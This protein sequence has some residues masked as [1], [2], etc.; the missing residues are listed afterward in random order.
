MHRKDRCGQVTA[1]LLRSK[2]AEKCRSVGF[3]IGHCRA[4]VQKRYI[5]LKVDLQDT[6]AAISTSVGNGGIGIVRVSGDDAVE[7]CA[8]VFE[9]KNKNLKDMKSH[10][11]AYGNIVSEGRVIDE[12]LVSVMKAPNTYTRQDIVEINTHGGYTA[13]KDVLE[14]VIKKGARLAEAGEFT[15]RAF[16]N[17]RIDLSKAEAVMDV[18]NAKTSEGKDIA[19]KKLKG[20]LYDKIEAM[21]QK[22]LTLTA[23][24]EVSVDYPEHDE[25]ELVLENVKKG[26]EETLKSCLSLIESADIG[27]IYTA[28]IDTAIIGKPNVGKSSLLNALLKSERAIVTDIPGTTRDMLTEHINIG[29]IPLNIAD[30]AGIRDTEDKIEKIGVEKSI[31][32]A[33][34]ADLK[35]LVLDGSKPLE[36]SDRELFALLKGASL[37]IVNKADMERK[38]DLKYIEDLTGQQPIVISAKENMG[39]ENMEKRIKEMF[40]KGDIKENDVY[41][42]NERNKASLIGAKNS[43]E[44]VLSTI[45]NNMPEDLLTM[46]LLQAYE[47]LGQITGQSLEDDVVDN[48]FSRFCLGK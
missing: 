38:I 45:E 3:D 48:I 15:K 37:V 23:D 20:G 34:K 30:T 36:E 17:G 28:G 9:G 18:I 44:N 47:Y 31:E 1:R 14:A 40:L 29:G 19:I 39:M 6:I 11:L 4:L 5:M 41:I 33:E 13:V 10:T 22:L 46:D 24:V 35:I 25:T 32:A 16:L 7:I 27:K 26:C 43:L 8:S 21:R 42:S 12:V 2:N